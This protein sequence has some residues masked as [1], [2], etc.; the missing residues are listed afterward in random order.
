M[1]AASSPMRYR[2]TAVATMRFL[3][4]LPVHV[5]WQVDCR[6]LAERR[7]DPRGG[8]VERRARLQ[9][10]VRRWEGEADAVAREP[11]DHVQMDVEDLLAGGL[12]VGDQEIHAFR[13]K[14]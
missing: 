10:A 6:V 11:R 5:N 4:C 12:P 3:G 2:P 9:V 7:A 14:A 1:R 8:L 13:P